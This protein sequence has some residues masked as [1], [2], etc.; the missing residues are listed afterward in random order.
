MSSLLLR[1]SNN[2]ANVLSR[3]V[4][5]L[6]REAHGAQGSL[7]AA[8]LS[9]FDLRPQRGVATARD[10]NGNDDDHS[11][12]PR[13]TGRPIS[14]TDEFARVASRAAVDV[15][16]VVSQLNSVRDWLS[17]CCIFE[18]ACRHRSKQ[19]RQRRFLRPP[20]FSFSL[21]LRADSSHDDA[22]SLSH[23]H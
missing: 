9:S 6:S 11:F 3:C 23:T 15:A 1:S 14:D 10:G 7:S 4:S 17:F 12:S 2:V 21:S 20:L 22:L 13:S 8:A 18:L 5:A 16:S 19:R